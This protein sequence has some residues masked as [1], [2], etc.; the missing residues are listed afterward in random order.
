[1]PEALMT[2][3]ADWTRIRCAIASG[4]VGSALVERAT[5]RLRI[6]SESF[7]LVQGDPGSVAIFRLHQG[8]GFVWEGELERGV[9]GEL[10]AG[11]LDLPSELEPFA[12][13]MG[14]RSQADRDMAEAAREQAETLG[15]LAP[16]VS[17]AAK[18]S[19]TFDEDEL[20]RQ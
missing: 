7:E 12:R 10:I 20:E 6:G 8:E 4:K 9:S 16:L 14:W 19:E 5:T 13:D 2:L 15:S 11:W 3:E 17:A 1:M 18:A